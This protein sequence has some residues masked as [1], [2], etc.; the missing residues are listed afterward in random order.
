MATTIA[1][2]AAV[3]ST[4]TSRFDTG[5]LRAGQ[6]VQ[7]F[8]KSG[9][10]SQALLF[11]LEQKLIGLTGSLGRFGSLAGTLAGAGGPVGM[12]AVA[13]TAAT[14]AAGAFVVKIAQVGDAARDAKLSTLRDHFKA[15][16][17]LKGTKFSIGFDAKTNQ[18]LVSDIRRSFSDLAEG[19][20]LTLK[21]LLMAANDLVQQMNSRLL[22]PELAAS[23]RESHE[24]AARLAEANK[25]L[26]AQAKLRAEEEERAIAEIQ[27]HWDRVVDRMRSRADQ[28]KESLRTPAEA[29][30]ASLEELSSLRNIGFIDD[31]TLGR[32]LKSAAA[33]YFDASKKLAEAKNT[34]TPVAALERGTTAEFSARVRG[35]LETHRLE[36]INREQLKLEQ[37]ALQELRN[38]NA[39]PLLRFGLTDLR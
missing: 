31:E 29:F 15:F 11:K 8:G 4:D 10:F 1:R 9:G 13:L 16:D 25:E 17:D 5:M 28:L 38:L 7:N 12:I 2:L 27:Q 39:K 26:R 35:T 3:L 14:A 36:A 23:L 30:R 34:L 18:E 37:Q 24:K 19:L 33:D 20:G 6:S 22:G 32:G 21:P